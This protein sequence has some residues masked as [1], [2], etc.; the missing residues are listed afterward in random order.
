MET[1]DLVPRELAGLLY[2]C[3]SPRLLQRYYVSMQQTTKQL[4]YRMS[5]W[6]ITAHT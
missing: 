5:W 1:L 2:Y 3:G 6:R 4:R